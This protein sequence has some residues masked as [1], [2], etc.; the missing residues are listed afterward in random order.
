MTRFSEN[1]RFMFQFSVASYSK[2]SYMQT[3]GA[4]VFNEHY[5]FE[6]HSRVFFKCLQNSKFIQNSYKY[7]QHFY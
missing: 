1:A 5:S 7:I 3:T 4:N 6:E 2:K